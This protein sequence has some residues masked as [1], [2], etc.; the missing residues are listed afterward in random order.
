MP[1]PRHTELRVKLRCWQTANEMY[2]H[3]LSWGGLCCADLLANGLLKYIATERR[4][5]IT[6]RP[7]KERTEDEERLYR[8]LA[9][10]ITEFRVQSRGAAKRAREWILGW[11]ASILLSRE[12]VTYFPCYCTAYGP[13]RVVD[14]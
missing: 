5:G 12:D 2:A 10:D 9:R 3:G 1:R 4:P 14:W 6:K 11:H 7:Y 13:Q 8:H